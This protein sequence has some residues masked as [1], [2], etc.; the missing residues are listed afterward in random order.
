MNINM[1]MDMNI[2]VNVNMGLEKRRVFRKS[3]K[4]L[5]IRSQI[6]KIVGV[7]WF[8]RSQC[9]LFYEKNRSGKPLKND[10]FRKCSQGFFYMYIV[11]Y[12]NK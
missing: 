2:N 12:V 8:I 1:N 10:P 3:P 7:K 9:K 11:F 6:Q 4:A 5:R